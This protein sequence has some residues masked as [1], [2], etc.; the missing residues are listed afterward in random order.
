[1]RGWDVETSLRAW[2]AELRHRVGADYRLEAAIGV[3]ACLSA[4]EQHEEALAKLDELSPKKP[5]PNLLASWLNSRA[6]ELAMLDRAAE[7]LPCLDDAA[8]VVDASTPAGQSLAG[9]I[10]GTRGIALFHLGRFEEAERHLLQAFATGKE[11]AAAEDRR[12]GAVA[13]QERWLEA[14]RW[15]WLAEIATALGHADEGRRRYQLASEGD[16]RFARRAKARLNR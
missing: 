11:A 4:R 6:Y 5:S 1:V 14:E 9:C 8:I 16:G 2:E 10:S 13:E 12:G 15:Y 3:A 7:A